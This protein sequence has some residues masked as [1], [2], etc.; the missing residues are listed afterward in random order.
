MNAPM[1]RRSAFKKQRRLQK[2][3]KQ[4]F[5][6]ALPAA[7]EIKTKLALAQM[8]IKK[9]ANSAEL[10]KTA[11][12]ISPEA[13]YA[14]DVASPALRKLM[15]AVVDPA[16]PVA[17]AAKAVVRAPAV[18]VNGGPLGNKAENGWNEAVFFRVGDDFGINASLAAE[19]AEHHGLIARAAASL[20]PHATGAEIALVKLH[21]AARYF[22]ADGIGVYG[23]ADLKEVAINSDAANPGENGCLGGIEIKG[24]ALDEMAGLGLGKAGTVCVSVAKRHKN[25]VT[26]FSRKEYVFPKKIFSRNNANSKKCGLLKTAQC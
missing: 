22:L 23:A 9:P 14:I 5:V 6:D 24:E 16:V 21:G 19:D 4:S 20:A 2:H 3:F 11:L 7:P 15:G 12:G 25:K 18:G 8:Q 1:N 17:H 26:L 10:D 13:L